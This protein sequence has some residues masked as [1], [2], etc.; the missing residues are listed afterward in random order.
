MFQVG[1][2]DLVTLFV[3]C[4]LHALLG[5]VDASSFQ[6]MLHELALLTWP[7]PL[8]QKQKSLPAS[9]IESRGL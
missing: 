1:D 2:G 6:Y 9:S 5:G 7:G 3:R 8:F 4:V